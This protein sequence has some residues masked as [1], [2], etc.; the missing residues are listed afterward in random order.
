MY[1]LILYGIASILAFLSILFEN[2]RNKKIELIL[3]IIFLIFICLRYPLGTDIDAYELYFRQ[4][5][6]NILDAL[7]GTPYPDNIGYNVFM[8]IAKNIHNSFNFYVLFFNIIMAIILGYIT[9]KESKNYLLSIVIMLGSGIIQ[10]YYGGSLRQMIITAIYFLAYYEFLKKGR[11]LAYYL[12][13]FI[14]ISFHWIALILLFVPIFKLYYEK[15]KNNKL[16]LIGIPVLLTIIANIFALYVLPTYRYL[17]PGRFGM[18]FDANN[19]SIMGMLSRIAI[20]ACVLIIYMLS[21]KKKNTDFDK[22]SV[23]MCFL[24]LLVYIVFSRN[25]DFSRVADLFSVIEIVLTTK[26]I[27]NIDKEIKYRLF[28]VLMVIG[29]NFVLLASDINYIVNGSLK[30]A[31]ITNYPLIWVWEDVNIEELFQGF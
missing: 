5:P 20:F 19:F 23:Y 6:L 27:T 26:L 15:F 29:L 16:I 3:L 2:K 25:A 4:T 12:L 17:I 30:N 10:I 28:S 24:S 7:N 9:Y 14:A 18:Y 11:Y 22:F 21:N 1:V 13:I 31:T 8:S